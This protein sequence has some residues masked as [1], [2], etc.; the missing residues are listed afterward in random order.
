MRHAGLAFIVIILSQISALKAQSSL[1]VKDSAINKPFIVVPKSYYNY[2]LGFICK[3][4]WKL[5]KTTGINLFF[6]LGSK[7]YVDFLEQ[8]PNAR[9]R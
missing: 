2:H 3:Q 7:E 1:P 6:R 9:K 4:E 5:Q 8:K